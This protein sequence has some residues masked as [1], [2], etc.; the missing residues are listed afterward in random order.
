MGTVASL[1]DTV[2]LFKVFLTLA[3]WLG[4]DGGCQGERK[5]IS[6]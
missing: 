3:R 6:P 5:R 1:G 2:G 4:T